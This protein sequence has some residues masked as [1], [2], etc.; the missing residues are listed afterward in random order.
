VPNSSVRMSFI[1]G[2][3]AFQAEVFS[4]HPGEK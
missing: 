3:K 4:A 2:W 1:D